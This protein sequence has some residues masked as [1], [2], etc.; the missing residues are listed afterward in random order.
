MLALLFK[1][2][3]QLFLKVFKSGHALHLLVRAMNKVATWKV[4]LT[5]E[6]SAGSG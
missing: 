5:K 4:P 1:I 6:I 3:K 2:L